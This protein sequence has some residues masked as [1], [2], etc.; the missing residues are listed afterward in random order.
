MGLFKFFIL[1]IMIKKFYGLI[2]NLLLKLLII[3][4]NITKK[5]YCEYNNIF[6]VIIICI[7]FIYIYIYIY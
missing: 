6:I 4:L 1:H 2:Y 7:S 3:F 5:F